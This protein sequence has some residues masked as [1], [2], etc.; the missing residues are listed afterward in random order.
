VL[1]AK[2]SGLSVVEADYTARLNKTFAL[3]LT[4]SYFIRNDLVT[5]QGLFVEKPEHFLGGEA[6][7]QLIWNPTS[8]LQFNLGGGAFLP[9]LG[10]TSPDSKPLWLVNL[11]IIFALY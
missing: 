11:N 7:G 6:Y 10:N 8:D 1:R 2:I 4:A 3:E 9:K 5:Y